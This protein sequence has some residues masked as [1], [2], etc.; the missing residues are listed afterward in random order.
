MILVFPISTRFCHVPSYSQDVDGQAFF[1]VN[2]LASHPVGHSN[3]RAVLGGGGTPN[4]S[5]NTTDA[6]FSTDLAHLA[7]CGARL[8][9]YPSRGEWAWSFESGPSTCTTPASSSGKGSEVGW[10]A[11]EYGANLLGSRR[12]YLSCPASLARLILVLSDVQ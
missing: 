12:E 1:D 11:P 8:Q 7:R 10:V 6:R 5:P 2:S 3:G 4:V 9:P